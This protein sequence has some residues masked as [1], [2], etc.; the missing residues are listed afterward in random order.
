MRV[1][2]YDFNA[3]GAGQSC[4]FN[5]GLNYGEV[6]DYTVNIVPLTIPAMPTANTASA[7][8]CDGFVAN[9]SSIANAQYYLLDVSTNSGFSSFV[10]GYN[11]LNVGN[12]T[13]KAISGLSSSTT[14]YYRVR[15]V[16]CAGASPSSNT[17]S[18]VTTASNTCYCQASGPGTYYIT[19]FTYGGINHSSASES[20]S[21]YTSQ[22][23]VAGKGCS[24][25]FSISENS[26][27]DYYGIWIDLNKDGTFS[28]SEQ[29]GAGSTSFSVGTGSI[30]IP[31]T[32]QIGLTRLRVILSLNSVPANAACSSPANY[33]EVEDYLV[34]ISTSAQTNTLINSG[35]WTS[36][37]NWSDGVPLACQNVLIPA[38][39]T[40]T[41]TQGIDGIC[42]DLDNQ[43]SLYLDYKVVGA[44]GTSDDNSLT[45]QGNFNNAGTIKSIK[46]GNG[47]VKSNR[48]T[49]TVSG[50]F[51]NSGVFGS[52]VADEALDKTIFLGTISNSGTF[53]VQGYT[54]PTLTGSA[55]NNALGSTFT[56]SGILNFNLSTASYT[57]TIG[58]LVNNGT[59]NYTSNQDL[60]FTG[61]FT[62]NG[63]INHSGAGYLLLSGLNKYIN[64]G[65]SANYTKSVKLAVSSGAIY[66]L[67]NSSV[68]YETNIKNGASLSLASGAGV[69][70]NTYKLNQVGIFNLNDGRLEIEEANPVLTEANF[71]WGTG[72]TCF[73]SGTNY[74]KVT[75]VLPSSFTFYNLDIGKA[76]SGSTLQDQSNGRYTINGSLNCNGTFISNS[77]TNYTLKKDWNN[78]GLFT[79]ASNN[80]VNF[81]GNSPQ[82]LG[83]TA[84]TTFYNLAQNNT[85]TGKLTL[86][87]NVVVAN[88]LT[89]TAGAFDLSK[90]SL[91]LTKKATTAI[92][93][94]NGFIIS[95]DNSDNGSG[96]ANNASRIIW[97]MGTVA[98]T[99]VFPFGLGT[100]T[101]PSAYIPF[102][103]EAPGGG[104]DMGKISVG[105]YHTGILAGVMTSWPITVSS[106]KGQT[107]TDDTPYMVHRFWQIDKT[108][109]AGTFTANVSFCYA[110]DEVPTHSSGS[111]TPEKNLRAQRWDNTVQGWWKPVPA[112]AYPGGT[113]SSAQTQVND[114]A[115]NTVTASGVSNFSPWALVKDISPLPIDLLSFDAKVNGKLVEI[116]WKKAGSYKELAA[117]IIE[118]STDGKHFQILDSSLVAANNNSRISTTNLI[119]DLHPSQGINYYRLRELA[120]DG[121]NFIYPAK[122]LRFNAKQ[123]NLQI[124]IYPNPAS[125]Y[126]QVELPT[127]DKVTYDFQLCDVAGRVL[128]Q[129]NL[130]NG[131]IDLIEFKAAFYIL[132]VTGSDGS[133]AQQ[134]F[135]KH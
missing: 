17:V 44:A 58:N 32:A 23:A 82:L 50:N 77:G 123:N 111:S 89:L 114:E 130:L 60:A 45:V 135:I 42:N 102:K 5:E 61:D 37:G 101:T 93:R 109:G 13:S 10:L 28:A 121:E 22:T 39:K 8:T 3:V 118:K 21:Y 91:E 40:V 72:T 67:N 81:E 134:G 24:S 51:I 27:L 133:Q 76:S 98:G 100:G 52:A 120:V 16:N 85:G 15:A 36:A 71:S 49:L 106:L 104:I 87:Q 66:T 48:S 7:I 124:L 79:A 59:I 31:S 116:S 62:N 43:G 26:S 86:N 46:T 53:I 96:K 68:F 95:E 122:A 47:A 4:A 110:D 131:K 54:S 113:Y 55:F 30:Q 94:T 132:K 117:N 19:N 97:N 33:G 88:M 38:G 6:E 103:L 63:I 25:M 35:S 115:N 2:L 9:W 78:N 64:T 56:N 1:F 112:S 127:Q 20:Y 18:A 84:V 41:I 105:T 11:G 57:T 14:Y 73:C 29:L 80:I 90:K 129:G 70:L 34:D 99:Y 92:G 107:G 65:N 12:L 126:I 69:L 125:D 108:G 75:Q 74:T 83:G 119:V 128:A